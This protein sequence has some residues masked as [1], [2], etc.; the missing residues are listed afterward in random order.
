MLMPPARALV[1][2]LVAAMLMATSLHVAANYAQ[3]QNTGLSPEQEETVRQL[4]SQMRKRKLC[5][6]QLFEDTDIN[7]K[8]KD[9]N[10]PDKKWVLNAAGKK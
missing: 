5:G 4:T 9:G 6:G 2:K 10:T 8:D 3:A 7:A 1:K